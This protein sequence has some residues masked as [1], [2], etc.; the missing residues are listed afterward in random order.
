MG[1]KKALLVVSFGTSNAS[2][3]K[4]T[5][6]KC[7]KRIR[8]EFEGYDFYRAWTSK[9]I[10]RKLKENTGE[11]IKF[12][13]EVLEDLYQKGYDEVL[14]QSLHIINGEEYDKLKYICRDYKDKF[15][16]LALGRPLLSTPKDYDEVTQIIGRI[17]EKDL[18]KNP[19]KD[20]VLVF[21]GHGT[22][23]IAHTS[24]T[25]IEYRMKAASIPA[26][27]GTVEG[28]PDIDTVLGQLKKD[29]IKKIHLR[30]FLLVA[31]VHANDDMAGD[32]D[33]S[34]KSIFTSNGFEVVVHMEGL[35]ENREIQKKFLENLKEEI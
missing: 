20:E 8:D 6:D 29:R 35:G 33:D 12:P 22:E 1:T 21:M 16:K 17:V 26:Y 11:I 15:E 7:E 4:L 31:G 32:S 9:M 18:G 13:D 28:Y 5:I 14:V 23:H 3:R 30:P 25:G 27:M 19:S 2:T 24:Y 10:I 34:W